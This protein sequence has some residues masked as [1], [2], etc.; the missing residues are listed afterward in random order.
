MRKKVAG[1][2]GYDG[3]PRA[4]VAPDA[5]RPYDYDLAL[6]PDTIGQDMRLWGTVIT[7]PEGAKL[8]VGYAGATDT[9]E[10]GK[11]M[12]VAGTRGQV[13]RVLKTAG[14]TI[15]EE[16]DDDG[17]ERETASD[18]YAASEAEAEAAAALKQEIVVT[19]MKRIESLSHQ[20]GVETRKLQA[21]AEGDAASESERVWRTV[22]LLNPLKVLLLASTTMLHKMPTRRFE[23]ETDRRRREA[24]QEELNATMTRCLAELERLNAD[25]TGEDPLQDIE[26]H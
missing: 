12:V 24:L 19:A 1:K 8:I 6:H 22:F 4:A 26:I 17:T 5:P 13:I 7:L 11:P 18:D 20:L 21:A 3:K 2:A 25:D 15:D 16:G 23:S 9:P 14:Y 10:D